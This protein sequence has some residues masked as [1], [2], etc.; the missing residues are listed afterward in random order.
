[1]KILFTG[2]NGFLGS[3]IVHLAVH[4]GLSV[5]ATDQTESYRFTNVDFIPANIL[6][7]NSLSKAFQGVDGV[8]HVAGLAHIFDKSQILREPFHSVNVMGT[9][10]VANA[11]V[12]AGVQHFVFISSVS[13]YGGVA[14][15]RAEASECHPEGPYAESKLQAERSLIELFQKEGVNLTILRLATLYSEEDPGNVARLISSIERGRFV[16]VGKGENLKSLLHREDAARA[17]IAAIKTPAPGINIYNVSAPPCKMHDIVAEI[18][19]AL[20]KSIPSWHVPAS[21]ALNLAKM[22]KK[23]SF[24]RGRLSN[25]HD[26][27]EKWLADDYYSTDKFCKAFNFQT[28]INLKEGIKREVEWLRKTQI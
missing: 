2:A 11:A 12:R 14:H 15:D 9:E 8:C 28:K 13:V 22:I 6:A 1:M 26:T 4:D 25:I 18:G 19:L 7:P 3:A 21:P 5:I 16:W 24:N 10:N 27:L 17:C 23:I 20:G